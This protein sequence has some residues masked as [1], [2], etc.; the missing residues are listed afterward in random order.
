[1]QRAEQIVEAAH[2]LIQD[3][4]ATFT[5]QELAKES[6]VALQTFYTHFGGKDAVLLAVIE[7]IILNA[8][9]RLS[10]ATDDLPDPLARLR[11]IVTTLVTGPPGTNR[12]V[13]TSFVTTEHW[14][15]H[16]LYPDELAGASQPVLDLMIPEIAAATAA[17]DLDSCAPAT[18]A[19]LIQQLV[20]AV[21]HFHTWAT[22]D[23]PIEVIADQVWAF[24]LRA[25]GGTDRRP[26]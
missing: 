4:G 16:R 3:K 7:D 6:G 1:M 20:L 22:S 9:R 2:R 15:L 14:R 17:G 21:F 24:C 12:N 8:C 25:L 13:W 5:T 10:T 19:W 18:D 23:E 26:L 11:L